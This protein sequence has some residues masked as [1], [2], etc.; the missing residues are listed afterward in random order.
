MSHADVIDGKNNCLTTALAF[1]KRLL[2]N[3]LWSFFSLELVLFDNLEA[4]ACA[5]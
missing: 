2:H 5:W 3:F 1:L 4:V